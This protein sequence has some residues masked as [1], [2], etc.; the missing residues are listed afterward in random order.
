MSNNLILGLLLVW[1]VPAVVLVM[2]TGR[3]RM[4]F[5]PWFVVKGGLFG[6]DDQ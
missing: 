4:V 1:I 5:W 6:A 2:L 3:F